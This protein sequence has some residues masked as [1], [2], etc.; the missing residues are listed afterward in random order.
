[1]SRERLRKILI[2]VLNTGIKGT[3][4]PNEY[5]RRKYPKPLKT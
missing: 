5:E 3:F 1:M 2:E 4:K